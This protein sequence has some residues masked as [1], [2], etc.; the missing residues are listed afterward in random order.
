MSVEAFFSISGM[1][2]CLIGLVHVIITY[3]GTTR[4]AEPE[5]ERVR[6]VESAPPIPDHLRR[7]PSDPSN[8]GHS[9][10]K[11]EGGAADTARAHEA[12]R[13]PPHSWPIRKDF[14]ISTAA[15]PGQHGGRF[16]EQ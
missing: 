8:G 3:L 12:P 13:R 10:S 4:S 1:L 2:I 5:P 14:L 16:A 9:P 11:E 6:F 15:P 7:T